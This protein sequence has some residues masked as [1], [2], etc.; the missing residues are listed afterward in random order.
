MNKIKNVYL[1]LTEY[2]YLQALNISTS[3][4][5]GPDFINKIYLVRNGRRL[6]GIDNQKH[7]TLDNVETIILDRKKP[8][9]VASRIIEENPNHFFI[10]QGNSALNVFIADKLASKGCE[11]SLGPDGYGAYNVFN[12]DY[13]ILTLIKDSYKANIYLF[14]NR[15]F[16]GKIH[17]FDYYKY[18]SQ[19]FINN[20]WLTH[21][22]QYTHR[23][24]NKVNLLQ[25][26][27]FNQNCLDF[28]K[29][30]FDFDESFP[31]EDVIYYFNQ[32]FWPELIEIEFAF[33]AGVLANFPDKRLVVK[34]HP[35]TSDLMK[36][37]YQE[38]DRVQIIES[39]VPA[40]VLLL[41]LKNC[42]VFTGWSS[43]LLTENRK[44]N[45]YFNYPIY[46]KSNLK[47][48]NK[49]NIIVL[50]HITLV[51]KPDLMQ[52]PNG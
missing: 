17:H 12:K 39:T 14:K 40:E 47:I 16:S 32:P 48:L 18:G 52:F 51:D 34:L 38:L 6:M 31:V 35:L 49:S 10:F 50:D 1:V 24:K 44:C 2:Q 43:V 27:D 21:P 41:S 5:S 29:N 33:L 4:Y 36:I 28:I 9:E 37:R 8:I 46:K 42:I 3:A 15:L 45:Y 19:R 30:C 23:A 20:I 13:P 7:L 25:L 22:K 26:P 11:I